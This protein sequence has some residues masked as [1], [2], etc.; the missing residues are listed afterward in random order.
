M[1]NAFKV[2]ECIKE[3]RAFHIFGSEGRLVSCHRNEPCNDKVPHGGGAFCRQA[4]MEEKPQNKK[5]RR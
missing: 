1:S 5:R 4:L 2:R 3:Q